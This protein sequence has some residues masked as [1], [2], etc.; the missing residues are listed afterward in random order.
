MDTSPEYIK[1]CEKAEEIQK[2]EPKYYPNNMGN[3]YQNKLRNLFCFTCHSYTPGTYCQICGSKLTIKE[4]GY[5]SVGDS[6][7]EED[8]IW[9][10]RQDQLQ[11]MVQ[12]TEDD[13]AGDMLWRVIIEIDGSQVDYSGTVSEYYHQFSTLEQLWL[14]FVMKEKYNKTWDGEKWTVRDPSTVSKGEEK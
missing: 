14:A 9:L 4:D 12:S 8:C 6:A 5:I 2:S 1:M 7:E 13:C 10:P 11:E 3:W